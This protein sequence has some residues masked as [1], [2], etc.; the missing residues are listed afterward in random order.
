MKT[1]RMTAALIAAALSLPVAAAA[2]PP[3]AR[4]ALQCGS[5]STFNGGESRYLNTYQMSCDTAR[6]IAKKARGRKYTAL[7]KYTCRPK[8]SA[9][10]YGLS[11]LCK[12]SGATRSVGF[13]YYAP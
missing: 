12:N 10:V 6:R 9:G 1:P 8:R 13:L 7:D 3:S 5:V 4:Q 11:Y 2:G